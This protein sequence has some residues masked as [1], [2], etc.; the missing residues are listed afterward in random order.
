ME[1]ESSGHR[2]FRGR[3]APSLGRHFQFAVSTSACSK[4]RWSQKGGCP[5]KTVKVATYIYHDAFQLVVRGFA[6]NPTSRTW[7]S[8]TSCEM[9]PRAFHHDAALE[10]RKWSA[11]CIYHDALQL[12]VQGPRRSSACGA[13]SDTM[14]A[15]VSAMF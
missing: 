14:C 1:K 8:G 6:S 7:A 5:K 12:V 10:K 13:K 2:R 11:A 9:R 15:C 3:L 4:T